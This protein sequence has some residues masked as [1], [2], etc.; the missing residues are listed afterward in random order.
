MV[1]SY[2]N[3]LNNANVVRS[4]V[5]VASVVGTEQMVQFSCHIFGTVAYVDIF[6]QSLSQDT[7]SVE[8]IKQNNVRN[9]TID[10]L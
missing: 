5:R 3:T 6:E 1:N 8:N 2:L 4:I 7:Q 9:R 10:R